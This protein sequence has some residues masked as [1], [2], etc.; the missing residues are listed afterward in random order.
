MVR[1]VI[2]PFILFI[3]G[4]GLFFVVST[5]LFVVALASTDAYETPRPEVPEFTL[6]YV[7]C[8]YDVPPVYGIDQFTGEEV[9]IERGYHVDKKSVELIIENP[10][11]T[12]YNDSDG[13][14]INLYFNFRGK[15]HFGGE[16]RTYPLIDGSLYHG[17]SFFVPVPAAPKFPASSSEY[18]N[19]T[20]DLSVFFSYEQYGDLSNGSQID[21]QVQSLV[22]YFDY[23][24]FEGQRSAWS[25]TQTMVIPEFPSWIII[26]LFIIATVV[27]IIYRNSLRRQVC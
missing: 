12:P 13:N 11:F 21:L 20:L 26:P 22:G 4:V 17:P 7:D 19:I 8:S 3:L 9:I 23:Y 10:P 18:T 15:P 25:E 27:V 1:S 6:R 24:Q 2:G 16:W 14:E 5:N